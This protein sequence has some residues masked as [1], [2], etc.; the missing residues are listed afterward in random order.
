M[1]ADTWRAVV[2]SSSVR[3]PKNRLLKHTPHGPMPDPLIEIEALSRQSDADIQAAATV[4]DLE[5]FRVKW[6]GT[7][8]ILK[9]SMSL[10]G[11]AAP[12]QK[13]RVGQTLNELK[14]KL[15]EFH[16]ARKTEFEQ[17]ATPDAV[18]VTE[19]GRRRALGNRHLVMKVVDELTDLFGR[20]GFSVAEGPEVEDE[21]HNFVALNIPASHPARDPLDNFYLEQGPTP[22]P[23]QLLRTQTSTV[24]VRVMETQKP[25]IRVVIPGRVYRPDTMDATHLPMFHQLEAL[26]VD[27]NVTMVDLK[28]TIMQFIHAYFGPDTRARFRRRLRHGPPQRLQSL[29][30]RPRRLVRLGLRLGHRT[31][32]HA[33][34]WHQR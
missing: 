30:H 22:G 2:G 31:H 13:K 32:R 12:E 6:L 11:Q 25:P 15:D 1:T 10:I 23:L 20:M 28:S 27:R 14:K 33:K 29:R 34:I 8:G 18:D 17:R 5:R 16:A 26:V 4:D 3:K 9:A 21:F 24:Q 7:K 19:P